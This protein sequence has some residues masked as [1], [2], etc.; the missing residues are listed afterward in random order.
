MIFLV[1]VLFSFE[2]DFGKFTKEILHLF[3]EHKNVED[4]STMKLDLNKSLRD[5][6]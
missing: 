3:S 6:N 5:L 4:T 1:M 2:D